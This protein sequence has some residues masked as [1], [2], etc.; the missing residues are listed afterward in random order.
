MSQLRIKI[1]KVRLEPVGR[2]VVVTQAHPTLIG[3]E[4]SVILPFS[5]LKQITCEVMML[6]AVAELT[7]GD[8]MAVPPEPK[9]MADT[10]PAEGEA[11]PAAPQSSLIETVGR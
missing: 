4:Q 8:A 6:E 3:Q 1:P 9:T 11:P 7:T 10:R 5:I 2:Y